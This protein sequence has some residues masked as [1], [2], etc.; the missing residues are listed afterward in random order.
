[1]LIGDQKPYIVALI[2]P[3]EE[4]I[5]SWAAARGEGGRTLE[6]LLQE[7][8]V[9]RA[10]QSAVADV[11]S[12]LGRFEQIKK[13][14]VLSKPLTLEDGYLTPTLKVKRKKVAEDFADLIDEMY[15][16]RA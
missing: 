2:S 4:E 5:Q 13:F 3:S 1:M 16:A 10:F 14:R 6:E 11:N 7:T 9:Q 8:L 15:A 12:K